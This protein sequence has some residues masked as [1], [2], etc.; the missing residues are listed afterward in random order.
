M[1]GEVAAHISSDI[2]LAWRENA[3]YIS[4]NVATG[5]SAKLATLASGYTVRALGESGVHTLGEDAFSIYL[6]KRD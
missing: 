2:A 6:R 1:L 4:A 3:A 5:T